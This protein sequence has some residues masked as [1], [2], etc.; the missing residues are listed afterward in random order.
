MCGW[1]SKDLLPS[2][3]GTSEPLWPHSTRS[4]DWIHVETSRNGEHNATFVVRGRNTRK[5]S[6]D[7]DR[8]INWYHVRGAPNL[9][10][11][12]GYEIS[13]QGLTNIS[14]W[15]RTWNKE[16]IV[17]IGWDSGEESNGTSIMSGSIGCAWAEYASM[18]KGTRWAEKSAK[19]PAL[20]ELLT[21]LPLWAAPIKWATPLVQAEARFAV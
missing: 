1:D 12:P 14:L 5:C 4:T 3:G 7:F 19:I 13:E 20:E 6:I 16:F 11:Q 18:T 2:P 21:F 10:F 9:R 15:S 8:P 17:D